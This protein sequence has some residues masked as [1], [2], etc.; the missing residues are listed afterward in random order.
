MQFDD[1]LRLANVR[2]QA[3]HNEF[4]RFASFTQP[5]PL[6]RY[7][8]AARSPTAFAEVADGLQGVRTTSVANPKFPS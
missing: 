4:R 7:A 8:S 1:W 3:N 2:K 5:S 6:A